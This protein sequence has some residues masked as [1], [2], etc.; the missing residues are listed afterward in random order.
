MK[1]VEIISGDF[2]R[3]A[4]TEVTRWGHNNHY[5]KYLLKHLPGKIG[6]AID[7][8][9]GTGEFTRLLAE[10]GSEVTGIDLS[11]IMLSKALEKAKGIKNVNYVKAD[12]VEY[13]LRKEQYD[14]IASIATVHHLPMEDFL[15]KVKAAL[16]PGGVLL[17]LDLY[18]QESLIEYIIS[19]AAAPLNLLFMLAKNRYIRVSEKERRAWQEHAKHDSYMNI[20][21]IRNTANKVIPGAEIR[22]HLFWRYSLV[23]KNHQQ[24]IQV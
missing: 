22:R 3:I 11:D 2:D 9:C 10:R 4:G 16:K 20:K 13:V 6:S 17:I 19:V 14:C 12:F 15:I 21:D 8:G 5:H 23:W 7:V 18:H 24:N 1:D